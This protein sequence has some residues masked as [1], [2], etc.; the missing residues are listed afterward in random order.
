[1]HG[2]NPIGRHAQAEPRPRGLARWVVGAV[3]GTAVLSFLVAAAALSWQALHERHDLLHR[4]L[5]A[6]AMAV[7]LIERETQALGNT[8]RGLSRSPLLEA[9][10]LAAFQ[11][12]LMATPRPD[13]SRFILWTSGGQLLNTGVPFG[14]ALPPLPAAPDP[15]ERLA[16]FPPADA[17]LS[18]RLRSAFDGRN[19]VA[20]SL[21]LDTQ[22]GHAERAL[23]VVVPEE[24]LVRAARDPD[25]P[26]G[27]T[28]VILD[29]RLQPLEGLL[30]SPQPALRTVPRDVMAR[31]SGP[32]RNGHLVADGPDGPVLAAFSRA[33]ASGYAAVSL[34]P[35]ALVGGPMR[36]ALFRIA[37]AGAVL[38][39]VGV[40]SA[41]V[42]MRRGGPV[43][44]LRLDAETS[45]GE[46][47]AANARLN[48]ILGSV[49][50]C[51]F[52]LDRTYRIGE[53]NAAAMRWF[54]LPR[55]EVIGRSYFDLV[56]H[57]PDFDGALEQAIV[58]RREF[59]AEL[60]STY[61]PGRFVDYRV[62]PSAEGASVFFGDVTE[63]HAAHLAI[64]EERELLQ[65]SLDALAAH[66]AFL[67]ERGTIIAVNAA[68]RRFARD[69]GFADPAHGIGSS[70][71]AACAAEEPIV[72][73]MEALVAGTETQFRTVY[74]C[75]APDRHRW[76]QLRANR[77]LAGGKVRIIVA[78]EDI[79]DVID[80]RVAMGEMSERLITLQEEERQR[81]AA[82]LHDSTAQHLVAAGLHLMHVDR[83]VERSAGKRIIDEIDRSLETALKELRVFTYLLHPRELEAEGLAG[84]VRSFAAGFSDRTSLPVAVRVAERTDGLPLDLQRTL[85]RIAQEALTNAHR[86]AGASRVVIALRRTFRGVILSIGDDGRG[87]RRP[88]PSGH[89]TLGVGIPGMRIR[90]HQFGGSLRI[91][92]GRHG[93]VVRAFIPHNGRGTGMWGG[94]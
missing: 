53:I 81:I 28:T 47:V 79:T 84:A 1:M 48:A 89:Q 29:R 40:A 18:E 42:L 64:R 10:D 16:K 58:H 23:T 41:A 80:A 38:L 33:D 54:D 59:R 24:H 72:R 6:S 11:R 7:A 14:G 70:Y 69:N 50:D 8:L 30:P 2:V 20:V 35:V 61:H 43:D 49:S 15:A 67:D 71:L 88:S 78:H 57:H 83:F 87:M 63:R 74:R 26:D 39:L 86:H 73:G 92:S 76:F 55:M 68:W 51:Y 32:D 21:R 85:L 52:T 22:A 37:L 56:G 36:T 5:T 13:G 75:D 34:A 62:Y 91:R 94:T 65:S 17:I 9:D 4:G 90:L 82:E 12:Q 93:T 45:R 60:R 27:W 77:F 25:L 3:A 44:A 46:L 19:V 31:L 66:V